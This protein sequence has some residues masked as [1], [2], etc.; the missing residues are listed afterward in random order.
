MESW[1]RTHTN[2]TLE[3]VKKRE[4]KE[5]GTVRQMREKEKGRER[6]TKVQ[7]QEG[8]KQKISRQVRRNKGHKV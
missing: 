8:P 6:K 4:M 7:E 1:E 5:R 3:N 2:E